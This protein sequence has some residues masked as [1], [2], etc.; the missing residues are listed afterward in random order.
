M[1]GRYSHPCITEKKETESVGHTGK[2][3]AVYADL[4]LPVHLR[5]LTFGLGLNGGKGVSN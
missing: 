4:W 5:I 1:K 3:E 2:K